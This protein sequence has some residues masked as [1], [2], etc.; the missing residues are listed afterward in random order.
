MTKYLQKGDYLRLKTLTLG[1]NLP[2]K[3]SSALHMENLRV[4][5]SATNLLTF[6]KYTGFDPETALSPSALPSVRVFSGGVSVT[7]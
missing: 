5:G 6:T 4:F 3:V 1:Y 2:R 7:F